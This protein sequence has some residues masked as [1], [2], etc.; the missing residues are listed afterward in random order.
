V[1]SIINAASLFGRII[2]G[3][4]ADKLGAYNTIILYA[5][6]SGL[7][8]CCW[9]R[10]TSLSGVVVL[11]LAYGFSSGAVIG[12]QGPCSAQLVDPGQ[13]GV[14]MGS[15]MAVL[16]IAGLLGSPINGW[17]LEDWGYLGLSLFSGL[18]MLIGT[19]ILVIARGKLD[20]RLCCKA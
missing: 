1:V 3:V 19:G 14:A 20:R 11:S 5:A 4:L 15:V 12:L 6:F 2:P 13:Y 16:S 10:A 7:V 8:C 17:V 9:T 18:A